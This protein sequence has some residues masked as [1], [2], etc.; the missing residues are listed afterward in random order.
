M[1]VPPS[2]VRTAGYPYLHSGQ[3]VSHPRSQWGVPPSPFRAGG[4]PIPV[5]DER[6]PSS[7]VRMG[8][9]PPS[10]GWGTPPLARWGVP[11]PVGRIG[12]PSVSRTGYPPSRSKVRT[13]GYPNSNSIACTCYAAG[14]MPLAFMQEDFLVFIAIIFG[15]IRVINI[16]FGVCQSLL[17]TALG[18]TFIFLFKRDSQ[19]HWQLGSF[20]QKESGLV[21]IRVD[22]YLWKLQ[23]NNSMSSRSAVLFICLFLIFFSTW[24]WLHLNRYVFSLYQRI[25]L[26]LDQ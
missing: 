26:Y 1:G 7:Q 12:L 20:V 3:G 24:I 23:Y 19:V 5:Q 21:S 8:V 17:H 10:A 2:Q 13:G 15:L 22:K 4:T 14:D 18:G 6:V 16:Y 9:S 25:Y 11:P